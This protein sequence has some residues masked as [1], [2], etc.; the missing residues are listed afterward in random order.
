MPSLEEL[1]KTKK[2]ANGKTAEQTYAV[3]NSKDIEM[4]KNGFG[5]GA[6]KLWNQNRKKNGVLGSETLIEEETTGLRVLNTLS[7]PTLYGFD[8][9]RLT[10]QT[11]ELKDVM[12]EAAR[13]NKNGAFNGGLLGGVLKTVNKLKDTVGSVLGVPQSIIPTKLVL[14]N[15]FSIG[16]FGDKLQNSVLDTPVTLSKIKNKAAGG[17]FGKILKAGIS[18]KPEDFGKNILGG[19]VD[20]GKTALKNILLGSRKEG[21]NIAAKESNTS[22]VF[23]HRKSFTLNYREAGD[24]L[25]SFG[26]LLILRN[27]QTSNKAPYTS[28]IDPSNPTETDRHD[29]SSA[30][31]SID[32]YNDNRFPERTVIEKRKQLKYSTNW[33]DRYVKKLQLTEMAL[34]NNPSVQ[35]WKDAPTRGGYTHRINRDTPYESQNGEGYKIGNDWTLDDY[36]YI[37]LRFFSVAKKTA[38][39]FI[40]TITGLI[41][42][43]SPTW[44]SQKMIGNPFN[45]YTYNNVERTAQFNFKVYA[46]S[47]AELKTNWERL[48]FLSG[49][50]YPQDYTTSGGVVPPFLKVTIGNLYVNKECFIESLIY[51]IDDNYNWEIGI[52]ADTKQYK[53]PKIV[54]VA[55]TLKFVEQKGNTYQKRKYGFGETTLSVPNQ[56]EKDNSL[57]ADGY[58][59]SP[60][61]QP[62]GTSNGKGASNTGKDGKKSNSGKDGVKNDL[63]KK[64]DAGKEAKPQVNTNNNSSAP[65]IKSPN[66]YTYQQPSKYIAA[67]T[68]TNFLKSNLNNGFKLGGGLNFGK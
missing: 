56:V 14:N 55:V 11:T 50:V 9:L 32:T 53:L 39:N 36:D 66:P 48:Q 40:G 27:W 10:T 44:D 21:M 59:L 60:N 46:L 58:F 24:N 62:G 16:G 63:P 34:G 5:S 26:S 51:T 52:D 4:S 28:T 38:A 47:P 6:F 20:A 31:I 49:L 57:N 45:F 2:L 65:K 3:Q 23:V 13:N 67:P 42:T 64:E 30:L 25:L 33:E 15:E 22:A 18:G 8:N 37:P 61:A 7:S 68:G 12:V 35:D 43:F 19:A 17:I 1:F 41:E 29:L 54:D